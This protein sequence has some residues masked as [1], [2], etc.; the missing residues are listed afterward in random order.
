MTDLNTREGI[1]RFLNAAL[2]ATILPTLWIV[3]FVVVLTATQIAF[4]APS[5]P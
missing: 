2:T 1:R 5:P 4:A 3:G